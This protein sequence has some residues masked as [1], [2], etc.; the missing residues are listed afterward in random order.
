[1][2]SIAACVIALPEP[3]RQPLLLEAIQSV[4]DQ[5]RPPDDMVIGV[6][7]GRMGEV[8]NANRVLH[9]TNAEWLAFLDD[10]DLWRP[11]H[12]EVCEQHFADADVVLSRYELVGRPVDTIEKW[13]DNVEDFR[14]T[15]WVGSPSMVCVRRDV[16]V[17]WCQPYGYF[18]WIDW[19]NYNRLLDK[20]ARFADTKTVTCTYRFG[21][22]SNGSW[23]AS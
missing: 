7:F 20:G 21:V 16:F 5:T 10:D 9:A 1:M 19:A 8:D 4:Y 6:D 13:H 14:Q 11:N 3:A 17:E 18:R 15:N 2:A 12:L 22:W 23:N